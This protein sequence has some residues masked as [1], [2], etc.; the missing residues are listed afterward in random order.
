MV[1]SNPLGFQKILLK[2]SHSHKRQIIPLHSET[3]S[4]RVEESENFL[5]LVDFH[6]LQLN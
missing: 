5:G 3:S 1:T 2:Y 4:L 6:W